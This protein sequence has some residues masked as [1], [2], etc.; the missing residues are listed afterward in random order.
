MTQ[1]ISCSAGWEESWSVPSSAFVSS[2]SKLASH[3]GSTDHVKDFIFVAGSAILSVSIGLNALTSH[4]T[5]TV[6]FVAVAALAAF[7]FA[8]IRT[9]SRISWLAALGI[10]SIL[11]SIFTVTIAVSVQDRPSAAPPTVPFTP[12]F[13]LVGDPSFA[14]AMQGVATIIFAFSGTPAF[15]PI[16]AEMKNPNHFTR[17]M[18]ICQSVVFATYTIIGVVVYYNCG[19]YVTSPAL[20]SAGTLMKKVCYGIGLPGLLVTSMIVCH[21]SHRSLNLVSA[22]FG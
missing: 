7:S 10:V 8:S 17:S 11:V 3:R 9:L 5:C 2:G 6:A 18:L 13:K 4:G 22:H 20:G 14:R 15:F 1:A 16:A 19:S 21:V 12:D